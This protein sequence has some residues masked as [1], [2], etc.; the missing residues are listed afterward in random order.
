MVPR[1][2]VETGNMCHKMKGSRMI[3]IGKRRLLQGMGRR[4]QRLYVVASYDSAPPDSNELL[5]NGRFE[6][7][8]SV[9]RGSV[10][11]L[12]L[13]HCFREVSLIWYWIQRL[14]TEFV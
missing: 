9:P 7:W 2:D 11:W 6:I 5:G 12:L 8:L 10:A 4:Y 3:P 14:V 13:I 1:Y